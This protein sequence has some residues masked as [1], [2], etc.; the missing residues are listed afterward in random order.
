MRG[1]LEKRFGLLSA[2]S[3]MIALAALAVGVVSP[4]LGSSSGDDDSR[5]TIRLVAINTE[6][7]FLDFGAEGDTLGD[8]FV[9]T[10]KLLRRGERVGPS[11]VDRSPRRLSL[12]P[13]VRPVTS[14]RPS[15]EAPVSTQARKVNYSS[16]ASQKQRRSG[17]TP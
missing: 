12:A 16:R 17:R 5:R 6:G 10:H 3:A 9:F 11:A 8:Y 7:N 2:M 14:S 1:S 15:P 13:T 4:A